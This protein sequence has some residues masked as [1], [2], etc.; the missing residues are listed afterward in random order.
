MPCAVVAADLDSVWEIPV[1]P[2]QKTT[3]SNFAVEFF[4]HDVPNSISND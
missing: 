2:F 4:P 3:E 1:S